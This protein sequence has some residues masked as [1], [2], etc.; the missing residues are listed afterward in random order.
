MKKKY[1]NDR[2]SFAGKKATL[3]APSGTGRH[4]NPQIKSVAGKAMSGFKQKK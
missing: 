4:K 3:S 2:S 1:S